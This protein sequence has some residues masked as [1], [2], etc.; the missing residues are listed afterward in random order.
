MTDTKAQ[1][2]PKP[3]LGVGLPPPDSPGGLVVLAAIILG[4]AYV[5][6]LVGAYSSLSAEAGWV[7]PLN[8]VLGVVVSFFLVSLIGSDRARATQFELE[9]ARTVE[10]H[11][12]AGETL[13]EASPLGGILSEYARAAD[14]QRRL[15]REH[16]YAAGPALYSTLLA[17]AATLL[18]GL[19]YATGSPSALIGLGLLAELGAF[20]LLALSAGALALSIGR[21]SEVPGF[22]AI[23]LRRWSRVAD[24]SFPFTHALTEVPWVATAA[25][26]PHSSS[27][28]ESTVKTSTRP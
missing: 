8:L 6:L 21:E 2:V 14:E 25:H 13:V 16:V 10:A 7:V 24:P 11:L 12:A 1:S 26:L 18:I 5:L 20:V 9:F 3:F 4:A 28:D 15:A 19:A 27:W 22:D 17:L 23:V